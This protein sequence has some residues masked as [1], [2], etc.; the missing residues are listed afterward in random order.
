VT[1]LLD[2]LGKNVASP[3]AKQQLAR[4]PSMRSEVQDVTPYEGASAVHYL[5]SER[6][7]IR[8]KCS[9]EGEIGTIFL[10]SEG[11]EGFRQFCGEMPGDLS[12]DATPADAIEAFGEPAFRRPAGRVGS[13]QQGELLR[14][15]WPGYSIHFQFRGDGEG[16]DLVT[17]MTAQSVPGRSHAQQ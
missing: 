1:P 13:Y 11:K 6:D 10:M 12:F 3:E 4:Y 9:P 7:G 8:I 14:F 15:D 5:Y 16:I 17:A 2:L